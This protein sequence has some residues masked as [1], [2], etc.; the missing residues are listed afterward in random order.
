MTQAQS[1]QSTEITMAV[2]Q[3]KRGTQPLKLLWIVLGLRSSLFLAELI[4]GLWIHSLTLLAVSGHLLVDVLV[5]G[6]ALIAAWLANRSPETEADDEIKLDP[7]RVEAWAALING[8]IL[9]G[10]AA[11][12]VWGAIA[13]FQTPAPNS[14][15]PMLVMAALGLALKGISA[16]L[17]YKDSH[18]NLNLRGV[19]LHAIADAASSASLILA[20]LAVLY[21]GWL[22]ADA[23]ASLLVAIFISLSALLL[24]R[25]IGILFDF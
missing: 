2:S 5:I 17:L 16:S 4:T 6:V 8:L 24:L 12:I 11:L 9:M 25:D 22:W 1:N 3:G 18:H 23:A 7:K 14:G 21:L 13:H 10:I 20:A 19:F 15:L